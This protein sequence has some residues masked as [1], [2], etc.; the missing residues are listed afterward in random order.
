MPRTITIHL[1]Y[2]IL[3]MA[4]RLESLIDLGGYVKRKNIYQLW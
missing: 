4:R 2:F 3:K 1:L